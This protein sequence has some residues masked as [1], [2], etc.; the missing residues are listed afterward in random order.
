MIVL[1]LAVAIHDALGSLG[2]NRFTIAQVK[3][4]IKY[5]VQRKKAQLCNQKNKRRKLTDIGTEDGDSGS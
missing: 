5:T 4:D 1:G 2:Y 3:A